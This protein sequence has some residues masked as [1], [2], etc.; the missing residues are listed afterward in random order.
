MKNINIK[1]KVE[2]NKEVNVD[3]ITKLNNKMEKRVGMSAT[4]SDDIQHGVITGFTIETIDAGST[5]ARLTVN[6]LIAF[7]THP[8]A[9][10]RLVNENLVVLMKEP[11]N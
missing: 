5:E 8:H 6:Y 2:V 1:N 10:M 4:T 11:N 9:R 7:G 3:S